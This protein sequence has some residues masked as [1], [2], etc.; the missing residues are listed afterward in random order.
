MK[1]KSPIERH[2]LYRRWT[3]IRQ[4]C[5]NKNSHDYIGLTSD[6]LD[7]F[8]DFAAWVIEEIGL[9]KHPNLKLHRKD[10]TQGWCQGN[11]CWATQQQIGR[12]WLNWN[13]WI[14]YQGQRVCLKDLSEIVNI[15][16]STLSRRLQAGWTA[17]EAASIRPSHS[18]RIKKVRNRERTKTAN[19]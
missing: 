5:L 11:I 10:Q 8:I 16:I 18:N 3:H 2:P 12:N 15:P 17:E 4:V 9:P 1:K 6:H 19:S 7:N 13:I 14:D